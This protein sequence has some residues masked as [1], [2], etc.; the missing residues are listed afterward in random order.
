MT[1]P[2]QR[3]LP[4]Y[5]PVRHFRIVSVSVF[6]VETKNTVFDIFYAQMGAILSIYNGLR[7]R[8]TF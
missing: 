3:L 7:M 8:T 5:R 4:P 1:V 2:C 6:R